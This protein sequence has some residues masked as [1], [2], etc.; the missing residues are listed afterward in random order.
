V[1]AVNRVFIHGTG[2]VSPAGWGVGPLRAAVE[3]GK[4]L[5]IT[6]LDRPGWKKPLM[7]RTVPPPS[8]RPAFFGHARLRRSSSISQYAVAASLE[9]LGNDVAKINDGSLRLGIVFCAM[10]GCVNY[11]RRFYDEVLREPSTA[12]PLVF[13]ETVFNAPSSHLAALLGTTAV[14]YT[15]VGDPGTFIQ[16]LG[17]AAQWLK[18]GLANGCLVVG[19]EEMDWLTADAFQLFTREMILS[20]GA[21][22]LYLRGDPDG[23]PGAELAAITDSHLFCDRPSRINAARLA[24]KQLRSTTADW[25]CDGVQGIARLDEPEAVAWADWR[26]RR[27]SPKRILG[28]GLMAAAAWQSALACAAIQGGE[29]REALVSVAGCNEQAIGA[30]FRTSSS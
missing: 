24:A 11:S 8:P 13:P 20:D 7:V 1:G 4:P 15:L 22:A 3:G 23:S 26:G 10:S 14:N 28:E 27:T 5:P 18:E 29:A 21:G 9:A 30:R 12:S 16:G 2:V 17:L 19:G 6:E 25:L